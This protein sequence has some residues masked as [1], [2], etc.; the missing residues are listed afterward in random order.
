MVTP[1]G[2]TDDVGDPDDRMRM[3]D[4]G[5]RHWNTRTR[6]VIRGLDPTALVSV[7]FF[8]PNEPNVFNPGDT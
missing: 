8:A 7:G 5:L 4:D 2:L 3:V 1:N 6:D